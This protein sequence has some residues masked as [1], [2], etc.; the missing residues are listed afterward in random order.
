MTGARGSAGEQ[1]DRTVPPWGDLPF[2]QSTDVVESIG[3]IDRRRNV[4]RHHRAL[5]G[6]KEAA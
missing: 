5:V 4:I 6:G 3:T 2:D 1:D